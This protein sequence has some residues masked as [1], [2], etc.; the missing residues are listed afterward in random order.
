MSPDK[1]VPDQPESDQPEPEEPDPSGSQPFEPDS[2]DPDP[3][4]RDPDGEDPGGP[5]TDLK[6]SDATLLRRIQTGAL[7]PSEQDAAT[8]LYLRYARRLHGLASKQTSEELK[9][10]VDPEEIVQSVFRTFFRR[11][12][13]GAYYIPQGGELWRL[14][15]VMTLNRIRR[16]SEYH[17]AQRRNFRLTVS[18]GDDKI[19][20]HLEQSSFEDES[21]LQLLR[22]V[23]EDLI[24]EL[25][26]PQREMVRLR[27]E[28]YEVDEIATFTRRSKRT[29]ERTLQRFRDRMRRALE[30]GE[31]DE[32]SQS[33]ESRPASDA[34]NPSRPESS[35]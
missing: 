6:A 24:G 1:P 13:S 12:A 9:Q 4:G 18:V 25:Q 32:H 3:D 8:E 16:A 14:L 19:F 35:D 30:D 20:Q 10:Q 34:G 15:L 28:G 17:R 11:A 29:V 26:V 21:A 27:I 2:I 5:K 7:G 31:S 22:H 33:T 23:V